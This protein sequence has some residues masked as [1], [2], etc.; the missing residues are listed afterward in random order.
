MSKKNILVIMSDEHSNKL[1]S[2]YGHPL[3]KTPHL[4]ALAARGC[5]FSSAYSNSPICLPARAAFATGKHVH[6]TRYWDN[7]HPYEG[8]VDSWGMLS[9]V[10]VFARHRLASCITAMKPMT[11]GLMNRSCQCMWLAG[12]GMF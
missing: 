3:A 9:A 11:W 1:L 6:E 5:R 2:C 7:A 10:K 4:D 8:A 12:R